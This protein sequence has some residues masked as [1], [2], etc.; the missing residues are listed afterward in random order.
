M[1]SGIYKISNILDNRIYI[2]SAENFNKRWKLH[3]NRL[4]DK[5]HHSVK[6]QNWCNK[7]SINYLIFEIIELCEPIKEILLAREQHYLDTIVD[8]KKDWNVCKIAGSTL[9][10]KHTEEF[11]NKCKDIIQKRKN[12]GITNLA[13]KLTYSDIYEIK[14]LFSLGYYYKDICMKFNITNT[15]LYRITNNQSWRDVPDYILKDTDIVVE[16]REKPVFKKYSDDFLISIIKEFKET[17]CTMVYL[18]KKYN[19]TKYLDRILKGVERTDLLTK[20]NNGL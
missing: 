11:K 17:K 9:G 5:K 18:R 12:N 1:L 14:R 19:M 20:M 7:Y 2:G 13:M 15:T 6:L 10:Y 16:K 8:F 3:L 4:K